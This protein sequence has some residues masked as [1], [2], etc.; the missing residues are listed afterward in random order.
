MAGILSTCNCEPHK[1]TLSLCGTAIT[2]S[3]ISIHPN[4]DF[5]SL[6]AFLLLP[7]IIFVLP[8]KH[9]FINCDPFFAE[10][11]KPKYITLC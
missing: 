8:L 3:Q 2:A 11:E 6:N 9:C 5:L 7:P 10:K 4:F 1:Q